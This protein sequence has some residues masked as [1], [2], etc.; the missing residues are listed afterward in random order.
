MASS[1]RGRQ[2]TED[3]RLA[4][5]ALRAQFLLEFNEL[6]AL[7]DPLRVEQ[8]GAPWIRAVTPLI[9]SFRERSAQLTEDYYRAFRD[10]EAPQAALEAPPPE[11]ERQ[12]APERR[13]PRQPGRRVS[14]PRASGSSS[15][16]RSRLVKPKI[17]WDEEDRAVRTSLAVTG[18][19]NIRAKTKRGK[20]PEQAAREAVIEAGGSAA[21]HVLTGGRAT[22]LEMV[23][24]DPVPIGWAR[25]TDGDPCF[26]CAM[27]ASRGP[28]YKSQA[29]ANVVVT[30]RGNRALGEEYHD[31]CACTA[32]AVYSNTQAWPGRGR[33]FQQ[34]W[35]DN[36]RGRY[37]GKDA[38]NAWR[39]LYEGIQRE[40][41]REAGR[42]GVV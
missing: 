9:A 31:H 19:A 39:R 37:S 42:I 20:S 12:E 32:E 40:A 6:W 27:L 17:I 22:H 25:V 5:L 14:S 28:V 18:P 41:A 24:A 35:N 13:V 33:E 2:L 21:R 4:Q 23:K 15:R 16:S 8:T 11:I 36:I 29:S 1:R 30:G 26:F 38:I 3:H 7:L 34:L 10:A